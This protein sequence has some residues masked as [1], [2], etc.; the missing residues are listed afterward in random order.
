MFQE[1]TADW[2]STTEFCQKYQFGKLLFIMSQQPLVKPLEEGKKERERE[3]WLISFCTAVVRSGNLIIRMP[4]FYC[5]T[6]LMMVVI[7]VPVSFSQCLVPP[8]NVYSLTPLGLPYILHRLN[9]P[10]PTFYCSYFFPSSNNS[11]EYSTNST[12]LVIGK[13]G[14]RS[15]REAG[16]ETHEVGL[17]CG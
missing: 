7:V 13:D 12:F 8:S 10:F 16:G 3:R 14:L 11:R 6:I 17:P 15:F 2:K 9:T 1:V 4:D 5:C